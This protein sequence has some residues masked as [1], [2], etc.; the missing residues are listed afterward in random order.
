MIE[1]WSMTFAPSPEDENRY[2]IRVKGS[3][4]D[5]AEIM[6]KIGNE[7]CG[8]PFVPASKEY[9]SAFFVYG[10]DKGTKDRIVGILNNYK[11][12]KKEKTEEAEEEASGLDE[13][14]T[15]NL[16]GDYTFDN[17]VVGP[18]NRFTHAAAQ[19]VAKNPGRIYNP[20]F[21]Y[22]GVGLGKTHLLH[23]VGQYIFDKNPR[24][25]ILYVTTEKF[26]N[27]VIEAIGKGSVQSF[28]DFYRKLDLLLI[29]DIQFLGE[30]ESTQ[31]EFFNTFNVLHDLHKQ[32]I[33]SS[34]K[35]PRQ[36]NNLE[37][38]LKSRFEWGLIA[39]LK[40]PNLEMRIAIL[41]KKLPRF[42]MTIDDN[43]LLYIASR[44]KA[45]IR[46]LE[47]FLKR[48]DAYVDLT[49]QTI[50]MEMVRGLLNDLLPPEE[51]GEVT[52]VISE[53]AQVP[54]ME[55]PAEQP[56]AEEPQET[57]EQYAA[58]A[59]KEK[60]PDIFPDI[61]VETPPD[62]GEKKP[63]AQEEISQKPASSLSGMAEREIELP[64][65]KP[66]KYSK[67]HRDDLPPLEKK[68]RHCGGALVYIKAFDNW[69][70]YTCNIYDSLKIAEEEKTAAQEPVS[71][72]QEMQDETA[73]PKPDTDKPLPEEKTAEVSH[74]QEQTTHPETETQTEEHQGRT[75]PLSSPA[76]GEEVDKNGLRIVPVVYFYPAENRKEFEEM[77]SQ[78]N[79]VLTK[80]KLK[81]TIQARA[82]QDYAPIPSLKYSDFIETCRQNKVSIA[83]ILGPPFKSTIPLG[84]FNASI[85]QI[86]KKQN[87]YLQ[88]IP[89]QD[90]SKHYKYLNLL[91][92]I[93]LIGH[94]N[95][96]VQGG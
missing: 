73:L 57:E 36:L 71:A 46:E 43:I 4:Q 80:H 87:C 62:T 20:L 42:N 5:L 76:P 84:D 56:P 53:S 49:K 6:G 96:I 75:L 34:D 92:D 54:D 69:Y 16:N 55:S 10:V 13:N 94:E 77:K 40:S 88:L 70:C 32:I 8:R 12:G 85:T 59:E 58:P 47:G 41:K 83:V 50:S 35:P 24:A 95:V 3:N 18:S 30:A 39:D 17:F 82:E 1:T 15:P 45:N 27:E 65:P 22:G 60:E 81:F 78:I 11:S 72:P 86:F 31:D 19:A 29:D 89:F 90:V 26:M 91:L 74:A 93:A 14:W 23:A 2:K 28:R 21:I 79:N 48:V 51:R 61:T 52:E 33:I 67:K 66:Q 44:L 7:I 64:P 37:D 9:T 25:R 63:P 38:R 68:C